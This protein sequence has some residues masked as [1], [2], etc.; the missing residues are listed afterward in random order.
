MKLP[1]L[2]AARTAWRNGAIEQGPRDIPEETAVALTYDGSTYAVM[3][4]T[5]A[6]LEDFAV[7]FSLSEGVVERASEIVEVDV[8]ESEAGMWLAPGCSVALAERRRRVVGPTGCGLCG[9]ESLEEAARPRAPVGGEGLRIAP[10]AL[11]A[12]MDSLE[13]GQTLGRA[14]RAVHA[15][16]FWRPDVGLVA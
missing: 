5:P 3:M 14:T 6:D 4:A 15:A 11:I 1:S 8:V 10:A 13:P 9:V 12:A 2:A 7:G 16:A